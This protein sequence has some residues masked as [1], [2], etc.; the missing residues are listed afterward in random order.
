MIAGCAVGVDVLMC[1]EVVWGSSIAI[2][3]L[4]GREGSGSA[5]IERVVKTKQMVKSPCS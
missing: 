2:T 3:G 1:E 4:R 5:F